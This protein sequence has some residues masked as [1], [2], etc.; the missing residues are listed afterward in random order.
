MKKLAI[1]T[2][3]ILILLCLGIIFFF[4]D[5][6]SYFGQDLH[7]SKLKL[8]INFFLS[9]LMSLVYLF[10]VFRTDNLYPYLK[11]FEKENHY[12]LAYFFIGLGSILYILIMIP[13]GLNLNFGLSIFLLIINL[14]RGNTKLREKMED[15]SSFDSKY[16]LYRKRIWHKTKRVQGIV[17]MLFGVC[18]SL[19]FIFKES[20]LLFYTIGVIFFGF[21]FSHIYAYILYR[22]EINSIQ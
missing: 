7:F 10:I 17:W 21:I 8:G 4:E 18:F 5:M 9:C 3:I 19:S 14:Y 13:R 20:N 22:Q 16:M 11:P 1:I 6:T 15:A 2:N 12:H